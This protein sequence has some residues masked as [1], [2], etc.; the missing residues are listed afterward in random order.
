MKPNLQE[1]NIQPNGGSA[2]H[3]LGVASRRRSTCL[4]LGMNRTFTLIEL[5][6][7]IAVIAILAALLLPALR[8]AKEKGRVAS[9]TN[10]LR[11]IWL[12]AELY[13]G[14]WND[15]LPCQITA[16]TAP[17]CNAWDYRIERVVKKNVPMGLRKW[18]I[19]YCPSDLR[20]WSQISASC[21]GGTTPA[22]TSWQRS[23]GMMRNTTATLFD[24]KEE[25]FANQF[26]RVSD[27]Q[28]PTGTIYIGERY[29][30]AGAGYNQGNVTGSELLRGASM[31][32]VAT[33]F[34]TD[35]N[36]YLFADGHVK[37]L[38]YIETIGTGTAAAPFGMWT[39]TPKD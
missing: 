15:V 24:L 29:Q 3:A 9:C 4:P 38:R 18:K 19:L 5:L 32:T 36:N 10:N 13:A 23:Y 37:F 17:N 14:D 21:G 16:A 11:Q 22:T 39:V 27:I 8:M 35:G 26:R 28:D 1:S 33:N 12:G 2:S 30:G 7:V 20:T 34:H 25:G 31:S 6:V